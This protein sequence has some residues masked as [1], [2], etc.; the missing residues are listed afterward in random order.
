MLL[1]EQA[2]VRMDETVDVCAS[3]SASLRTYVRVCVCVR[4]CGRVTIHSL[5]AMYRIQPRPVSN[6]RDMAATLQE[7]TGSGS[8]LTDHDICVLITMHEFAIL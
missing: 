8:L 3:V 2:C 6:W 4:T 1:K 7:T 5:F